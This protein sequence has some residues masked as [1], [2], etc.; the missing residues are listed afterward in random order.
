M[1][2]VGIPLVVFTFMGYPR[3]AKKVSCDNIMRICM[4]SHPLSSLLYIPHNIWILICSMT[5]GRG[6]LF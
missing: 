1:S 2:V 5:V 6:E 4:V 3:L